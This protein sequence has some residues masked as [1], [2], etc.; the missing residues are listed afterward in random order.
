MQEIENNRNTFI[1]Q[2]KKLNQKLDS[3]TKTS[4]HPS[5]KLDDLPSSSSKAPQNPSQIT[6]NPKSSSKIPRFMKPT[7]C[8]TRKSGT[9]TQIPNKKH[10]RPVR[11]KQLPLSRA[12]SV[13]FPLKNMT[14]SYSGSSIS[15]ASCLVGFNDDEIDF[16]S[17]NESEINHN[18][19]VVSNPTRLKKSKPK[20]HM[21]QEKSRNVSVAGKDSSFGYN[22]TIGSIA[23]AISVTCVDD[24]ST[25]CDVWC[26]IMPCDDVNDTG[27]QNDDENKVDWMVIS[28]GS[29]QL[30][31]DKCLSNDKIVFEDLTNHSS[32]SCGN[33]QSRGKR[34]KIH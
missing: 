32:K 5:D 7:I 33:E 34:N 27:Y 30:E 26:R 6:I 29:I 9:N 12:E 23:S 20:E 11:R 4:T 18:H 16:S 3:L 31:D 19:R 15:R 8:S 13:N 25:D 2:I 28:Q 24:S 1:K 22:S 14:E 10:I 17:V 21:K